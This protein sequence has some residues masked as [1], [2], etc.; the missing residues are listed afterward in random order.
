MSYF[1]AKNDRDTKQQPKPVVSETRIEAAPAPKQADMVSTLGQGMLITGNIVCAGSVQIHG[2][3]IGDIHAA[4]LV[5]CEGAKVEGKIVAPDTAIKGTFNG[6]IHSNSVKL[7]ST[8]VVDGEI[9]NK[10]LT[11]EQN[12]QFEGVARRLEQPVASPSAAQAK[13]EEKS[14][15][16]APAAAPVAQIVSDLTA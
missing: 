2:R 10:S 14:P 16:L 3:V 6:T 4:Q 15:T 11:I 1:T 5:I 7:F 12:A 9:F 8:A 13:G